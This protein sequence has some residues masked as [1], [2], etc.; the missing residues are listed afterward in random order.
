M[1][2]NFDSRVNIT[3]NFFLSWF[4][5]FEVW[6]AIWVGTT[7]NLFCGYDVLQ[8]FVYFNDISVNANTVSVRL[9]SKRQRINTATF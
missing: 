6:I 9:K 8:L 2:G 4:E 7:A 1:Q 5:Y 3:A